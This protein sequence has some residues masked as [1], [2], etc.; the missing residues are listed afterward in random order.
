MH[1]ILELVAGA[2]IIIGAIILMVSAWIFTMILAL[3]PWLIKV[4]VLAGLGYA[5]LRLFGVI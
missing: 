4:G 1:K 5:A 3:L 2:G